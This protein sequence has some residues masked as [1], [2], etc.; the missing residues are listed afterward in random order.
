MTLIQLIFS[1]LARM[2]KKSHRMK[3]ENLINFKLKARTAVEIKL[4]L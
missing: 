2:N 3:A 1:L 4:L